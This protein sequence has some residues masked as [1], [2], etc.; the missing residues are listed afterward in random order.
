MTFI[1]VV[2]RAIKKQLQGKVENKREN[3]VKGD[4][5]DKIKLFFIRN[6]PV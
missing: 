1:C 2:Y 5:G 4:A 3:K 6:L